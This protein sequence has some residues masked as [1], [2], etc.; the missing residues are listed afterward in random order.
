MLTGLIRKH[1]EGGSWGSGSSSGGPDPGY[2]SVSDFESGL[3]ESELLRP[4]GRAHLPLST[5]K[6]A[7]LKCLDH[8]CDD[9][10]NQ[11]PGSE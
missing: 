6:V 3:A 5:L 1:S 8:R 7:A 4:G 2:R 10:L 9:L 11:L